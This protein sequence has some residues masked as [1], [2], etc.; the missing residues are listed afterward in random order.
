VSS[1]IAEELSV[2][3][4]VPKSK[5]DVVANPVDLP[6]IRAQSYEDP[7]LDLSGPYIMGMGR[8][9]VNK[10]F[11]LLIEAFALSGVSDKLVILGEG[12]ER[13]TLTHR[14][15]ELRLAD[16]VLMPGF[17]RNPFTMLRQAKLFV[18]PSNAEGFPNGLLE[19]MA[20]GIPV[21]STNCPSGPSEIL[22]GRVRGE[23][24]GLCFAE[25]GVLVPPNSPQLMARALATMQDPTVRQRYSEAAAARA[26][27]FGVE[28][29][30][31][32]YWRIIRSEI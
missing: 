12:P 30:T 4:A 28:Q 13:A 1:G 7:V 15:G 16:R 31:S 11:S 19:A 6:S 9:V 10:N 25:Y 21:I 26:A 17:L 20:L 23:I 8:L 22:A 14:I 2:S 5:I 29:A 24:D 18:L 32:R 3:F 27:E